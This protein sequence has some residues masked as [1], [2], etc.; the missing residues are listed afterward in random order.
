MVFFLERHGIEEVKN[1]ILECSEASNVLC[2][3]DK[4]DTE[5]Y[6]KP[7][8]YKDGKYRG[9]KYDALATFD[10]T[11][12]DR[13][14]KIAVGLND[15]WKFRLFDFYIVEYKD[16]FPFIPHVENSGRICA[17]DLEGLLIE[18]AEN[19]FSSLLS[20]CVEKVADILRKGLSGENR[21]D[22]IKEFHSYW[23]YLP[24]YEL[25]IGALPIGKTTSRIK[26]I[27][28]LK[29][30]RKN[31]A[32]SIDEHFMKVGTEQALASWGWSGT[33]H[34]GCYF[35]IT[36]DELIFPPDPSVGLTVVYCNLLL[37]KVSSKNSRRVL[38]KGNR[39]PVVIFGIHEINGTFVTIGFRVT[40]GRIVFEGDSLRLSE[41]SAVNPIAV[42]RRDRKFLMSREEESNI[43]TLE[44]K[45][46]LLIGCGSIG[47]YL[48]E[49]MAKAGCTDITLIDDDSF[50]AENIFRHVLG[51]ESIGKNKAT[52]LTDHLTSSIPEI[53]VYSFKGTIQQ[54]VA[55]RTIHPED[56]DVII[57]AT[58]SHVVNRWI[59]AYACTRH[60][61]A[62]FIYVWNE[63]LDLGCHA[64]YLKSRFWEN[65][66]SCYESII[67][68]SDT[69]IFDQ[70]AFCEKDQVVSRNQTGCGGSYIPY[71]SD[72][73]LHSALLAMSLLKKSSDGRIKESTLISEKGEG[74][75]F[76]QS[77]LQTSAVYD[78]QK[79]K[80]E[81]KSLN[82]FG[83]KCS[84][85]ENNG[86]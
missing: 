19:V 29:D 79:Q 31:K 49:L 23:S 84:T 82:C 9:K 18:N 52:A 54:A 41:G 32:A 34:N 83:S 45:K 57:S 5:F 38:D 72:A 74:Y 59:N 77:G 20:E 55:K 71:G 67:A 43:N 73:S 10:L 48:A 62:E 7:D 1:A 51:K 24:G 33:V 64:L 68:K 28:P 53:K 37:S 78:A 6:H 66:S 16:G 42:E 56:Y 61:A 65:A 44:D 63:P 80:I 70:S 2:F 12:I 81:E 50:K 21:I 69:G 58:G 76:K 75:Y 13:K 4:P 22:F 47:G 46:Y 26:Y 36:P 27:L 35:E 15:S 85:C 60:L 8:G 39:N 86:N 17:V 30:R 25:A 40:D 14:I 11:V 3:T